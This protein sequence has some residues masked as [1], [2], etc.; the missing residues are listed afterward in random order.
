MTDQKA[1]L[2]HSHKLTRS[3]GFCTDQELQAIPHVSSTDPAGK[4]KILSW[5]NFQNDSPSPKKKKSRASV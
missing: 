2:M 1:L 3:F 4:N 5:L